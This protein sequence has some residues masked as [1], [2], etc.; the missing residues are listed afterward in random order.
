MISQHLSCVLNNKLPENVLG[1]SNLKLD[2]SIIQIYTLYI[3]Y[4]FYESP[5]SSSWKG[6]L[7][8]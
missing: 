1:F 8:F 6:L 7:G 5:L 3:L 2:L 4:L